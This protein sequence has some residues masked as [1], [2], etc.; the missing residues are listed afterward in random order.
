M[1]GSPVGERLKDTALRLFGYELRETTERPIQPGRALDLLPPASIPEEL[2][3]ARPNSRVADA[4]SRWGAAVD[5]ESSL[6]ISPQVRALVQNNLGEWQGETI[7]IS[8]KWVD[9]EV[10]Q[11][12]GE[13]REIAK[14]VL[15]VAKA[16]WQFDES[17][18]QAVM[19][20][21]VDEKRLIRILA[22]T[23]FRCQA[24]STA[25]RRACA[26]QDARPSASSGSLMNAHPNQ[27]TA[28]SNLQR[29]FWPMQI[30]KLKIQRSFIRIDLTALGTSTSTGSRSGEK[31][32]GT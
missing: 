29:S 12:K 7:P 8:R 17:L 11:L 13:D 1:D 25:C 22:Y 5:R 23:A 26:C 31:D 9:I 6:A 24:I 4:L 14:L 32:L 27:V 20:D 3:W 28:L 16:S 18:V 10:K 2:N 19:Q 15:V 21:E 30:Q